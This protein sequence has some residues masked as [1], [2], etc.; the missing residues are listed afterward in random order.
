MKH[1]E[2][3][4][5]WAWRNR[6]LIRSLLSCAFVAILMVVFKGFNGVIEE[7]SVFIV[8]SVV[9]ITY[10]L[11]EIPK[12]R[13]VVKKVVIEGCTVKLI[14]YNSK[15]TKFRLNEIS[16]VEVIDAK[17]GFGGYPVEQ[18]LVSVNSKVYFK[19]PVNIKGFKEV[20]RRFGIDDFKTLKRIKPS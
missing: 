6:L 13:N 12:E 17:Y 14:Q 5:N 8:W 9:I 18:L 20:C 4:Y 10:N 3:T 7:P 19:I 1:L 2:Y 16:S 11:S 15:E